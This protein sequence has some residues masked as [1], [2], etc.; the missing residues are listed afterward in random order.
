VLKVTSLTRGEQ[1]QG[2]DGEDE[3]LVHVPSVCGDAQRGSGVS[4]C[5]R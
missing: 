4:R 1:Q 5:V 3:A 2:R